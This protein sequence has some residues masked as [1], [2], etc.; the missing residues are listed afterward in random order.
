[1]EKKSDGRVAIVTG[2]T[3]GIGREI[4]LLFARQG[5]KAVVIAAK[6]TVDTDQL[7][8]TIYSVAK[9]VDALGSIGFP[10]R[11]DVQDD[12]SIEEMV[13]QVVSKF[14]RIDFLINNAGALW[15]KK[16]IDTPMKRYDL[17]N[18]INARGSFAV[19]RAC[20]P[21]FLKQGYG[22]VV[23]MS[24]PIDLT[25]MSGKV[26]YFISKYGMTML[27]HGLGDELKGTGITINALWPSTMVESF[28]TINHKLGERALWRKA[29]IIADSTLGI[30]CEDGS[31]TGHALIDEDYLRQRQGVTC[32]KK[33]RCDPN[34]EP[35]RIIGWNVGDVGLISDTKN[36]NRLITT[37]KL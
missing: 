28:A 6:T 11:L 36:K 34:V 16:V 26:G 15:W 21:I 18:D 35:P 31:F 29:S 2:S 4:A 33:Y 20:L 32:F 22:R 27:A 5:C 13:T 24:P 14:G 8:G 3:R 1:M 25:I 30:V 37:S 12:V 9:E 10:W 23:V 19:T 7:P 17:I